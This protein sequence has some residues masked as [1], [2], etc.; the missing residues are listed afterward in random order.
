MCN[1]HFSET[2]NPISSWEMAGVICFT[3][4]TKFLI[5]LYQE[6]QPNIVIK[7]EPGPGL[8]S[9]PEDLLP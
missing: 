5:K 4:F 2:T 3:D 7:Q 1:L 6:C 9:W 8:K